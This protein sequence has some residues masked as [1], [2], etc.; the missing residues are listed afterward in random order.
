MCDPVDYKYK[1]DS[2]ARPGLSREAAKSGAKAL[3]MNS[4][5]SELMRWGQARRR[6]EFKGWPESRGRGQ[7]LHREPL[8]CGPWLL[9]PSLGGGGPEMTLLTNDKGCIRMCNQGTCSGSGS[10]EYTLK[11]FCPSPLSTWL[12][13]HLW[14]HYL[15]PYGIVFPM[16]RIGELKLR[17]ESCG[18]GT[19][20]CLW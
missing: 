11:S 17:A 5:E 2:R 14:T 1:V 8:A 6:L 10:A 16:R 3:T 15:G 18:H 4:E 13:G 7:S 19:D 12:S 9:P 20:L